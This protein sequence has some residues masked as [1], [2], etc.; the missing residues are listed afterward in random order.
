MKTVYYGGSILTME[1]PSAVEAMIVEQGI[2]SFTGSYGAACEQAGDCVKVD[3]EGKVILP[4]FIDAHSHFTQVAS[5][6]LQVS[7]EGAQSVSD[8]KRRVMDYVGQTKP[9]LDTYVTPQYRGQDTGRFP[10]PGPLW[11]SPFQK[12]LA[13]APLECLLPYRPQTGC[14]RRARYRCL[15]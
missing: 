11:K 8:M 2:I 1:E 12:S 6:M 3:L 5:A 7:F 4:A 15:R 10:V 14:F 13:A 9:Q